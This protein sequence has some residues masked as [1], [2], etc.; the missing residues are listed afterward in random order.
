MTASRVP[1]KPSAA[2]WPG[3]TIQAPLGR[4]AAS[5]AVGARGP[6]LCYNLGKG[7]L[8]AA[9]RVGAGDACVLRLGHRGKTS[10]VGPTGG[11]GSCRCGW[12][13]ISCPTAGGARATHASQSAAARSSRS[14]RQCA[15][16]FGGAHDREDAATRSHCDDSIMC[17]LLQCNAPVCSWFLVLM[18]IVLVIFTRDEVPRAACPQCRLVNRRGA[19]F[20]ARC[21]TAIVQR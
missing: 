20:C 15:L 11:S 16:L 6:P 7:C 14:G 13:D 10:C 2:Q 5:G 8:R 17:L 9:C 4:S 1:K 18:V 21:G 12:A 3:G 19:R